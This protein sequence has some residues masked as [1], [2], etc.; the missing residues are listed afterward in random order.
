MKLRILEKRYKRESIFVIQQLHGE[1]WE[2]LLNYGPYHALETA[3]EVADIITNPPPALN[4]P[5]EIIHDHP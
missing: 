1:A 3:R 2:D 4:P 5:K